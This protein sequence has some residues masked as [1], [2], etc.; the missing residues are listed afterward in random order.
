MLH[1]KYGN[2]VR[3]DKPTKARPL[4]FLF[5]PELC[6]NMY[7]IQGKWPMRVAME[8]L[9][10]YRKSREHIYNG[11]YGLT[12]RSIVINA[13]MSNNISIFKYF[14]FYFFLP[15]ISPIKLHNISNLY[16]IYYSL[17]FAKNDFFLLFL[18]R[19]KSGTSFD[20]KSIRI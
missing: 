5:C 7:Q 20:Q 12:T 6:K 11:Q 13:L 16:T 9:H 3:F 19:E 17:F 1:D 8:P 4:I 18:V 14:F 2:I 15:L 10:Y